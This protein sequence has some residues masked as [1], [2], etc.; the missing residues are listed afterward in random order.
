MAVLLNIWR[1]HGQIK[2]IIDYFPLTLNTFL[3]NSFLLKKE[4]IILAQF[5]VSKTNST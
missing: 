1:V 2:T 3:K 5:F 4:N